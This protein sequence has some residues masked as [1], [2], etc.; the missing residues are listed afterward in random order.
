MVK[1]NLGRKG[2]VL[3]THLNHSL[4]GEARADTQARNLEAET[5]EHKQQWNSG[6]WLVSPG[7]LPCIVQDHVCRNCL[8]HSDLGHFKSIIWRGVPSI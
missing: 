6:Y 2:F 7:L 3:L 1:I 8:A 5:T 4:L